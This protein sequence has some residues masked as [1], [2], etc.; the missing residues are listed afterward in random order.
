MNGAMIVQSPIGLL[1]LMEQDGALTE[2]RFGKKATGEAMRETALLLQ[3]A[4]ELDEY[5]QGRRQTFSVPLAPK[6]TPFQRKC[7]DALC[8]IPYG[9]TRT[10][11]QQ[12]ACIGHPKACRAVG[13][14]NHRNPLPIF[15]P[16][17]RVVGANGTLTGYAGG[18]AIKEYLLTLER[19]NRHDP[20]QN[21]DRLHDGTVHGE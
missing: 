13:M 19:M 21:Q 3:A 14:G 20:A 2:V 7:W 18:L 17:H 15:I 8:A 11:G 16:C 5:F 10:Y 4:Q 9:E 1:T 6:G 12:A